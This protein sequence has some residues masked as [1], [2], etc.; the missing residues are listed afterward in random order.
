M[1]VWPLH[2]L[3]HVALFFD[4]GFMDSKVVPIYNCPCGVGACIL[5]VSRMS[6]N[7]GREFWCCP[8]SKKVINFDMLCIVCFKLMTCNNI[9]MN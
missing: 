1:L 2:Q 9:S 4:T 6:K 3:R 5:K 7:P 8:E